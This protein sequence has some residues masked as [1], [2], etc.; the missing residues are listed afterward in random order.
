MKDYITPVNYHN[1]IK[2]EYV[3]SLK[4]L[5][6]IPKDNGKEIYHGFPTPTVVGPKTC[7][8]C[9]VAAT[10]VIR[11]ETDS[12]GSELLFLCD[13]CHTGGDKAQEEYFKALD[14]EDTTAPE[15]KRYVFSAGTNI[16]ACKDYFRASVSLREVTSYMRRCEDEADALGGF[17]PATGI[18][19]VTDDE[20][21]GL[22]KA[23]KDYM[24]ELHEEAYG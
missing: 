24:D 7:E 9:G 20:A 13:A 23:H 16:E 4:V 5:A 17:Y 22:H 11:G 21:D 12:Y 8:D 19:L 14:I 10:V 15:G 2:K 6:R 18:R 1:Q 3:M